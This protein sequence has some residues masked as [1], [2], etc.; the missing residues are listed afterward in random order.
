M[1]RVTIDVGMNRKAMMAIKD[2][3][4]KVCT[5]HRWRVACRVVAEIHHPRMMPARAKSLQRRMRLRFLENHEGSALYKLIIV[6]SF[7][8]AS[9]SPSSS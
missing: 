2:H 4:K 9:A 8:S 6:S 3:A 7:K 5:I 1:G